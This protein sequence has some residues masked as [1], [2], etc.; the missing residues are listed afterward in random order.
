ME[1][2]VAKLGGSAATVKNEFETLNKD[3]IDATAQH[4]RSINSNRV[5][6]VHGA[7]SFGHYQACIL[8]SKKIQ[9]L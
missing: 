6:L 1:I 9:L 7:G 8:S 2:V 5:I 3:I 4:V